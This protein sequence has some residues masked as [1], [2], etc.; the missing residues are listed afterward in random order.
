MVIEPIYSMADA[1]SS[2]TW[3]FFLVV[4]SV[5]RMIYYLI[6]SFRK[7]QYEKNVRQYTIWHLV[8]YC[9]RCLLICWR[10]TSSVKKQKTKSFTG[11]HVACQECTD[12]HLGMS[13][14]KS[15]KRGMSHCSLLGP[16]SLHL[17][18]RYP[19]ICALFHVNF[20]YPTNVVRD[21][22]SAWSTYLSN[23]RYSVPRA[24]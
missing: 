21:V 12:V 11:Q 3:L 18:H 9:W 23:D 19:Q 6:T 8:G 24:V 14:H 10:M 4:D 1:G 7:S 16:F 15:Q 20:T 5:H 13:L 2:F 17:N 22:K